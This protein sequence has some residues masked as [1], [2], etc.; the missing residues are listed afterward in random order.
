LT[1]PARRSPLLTAALAL[2]LVVAA[3]GLGV[4][5]RSA[6]SAR[7]P[8]EAQRDPATG[9]PPPASPAERTAPVAR[10]VAAAAPR[11]G[12]DAADAAV[13]AMAR[14]V[15]AALRRHDLLV[16]DHVRQATQEADERVFANLALADGQR[17]AIRLLNERHFRRTAEQLAEDRPQPDPETQAGATIAATSAADHARRAALRELLGADAA[18]AFQS[19][20]AREI[21]RIQ[22]RYRAQWAE[23][24]EEQ[25][26]L[27]SGLPPRAH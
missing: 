2:A 1:P 17:V 21:R 11:D 13:P 12:A 19:L 23:E 3:T 25:A 5:Y 7:R 9:A 24:L 8:V 6:G 22:R 15:G 4:L 20:E 26:P 18:G 16:A 10:L 27:P 14:A